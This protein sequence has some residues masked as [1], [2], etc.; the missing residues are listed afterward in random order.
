MSQKEYCIQSDGL[1][2]NRTVYTHIIFKNEDPGIHYH[3]FIEFF[4]VLEGEC[5]HLLEGKSTKITSG[6]ACLLTPNQVHS[7][8][9]TGSTFLHRDILFQ[10]D[11]FRSICDVY[12]P[13]LYERFSTGALCGQLKMTSE[14]LNQLELL[15]QPFALNPDLQDTVYPC[16][17]CTFII[18]AFLSQ[19]I[20]SQT[21]Y[22][23][24]I[25]KL[26]SLLS[27]PEN[28]AVDQ[29]VL[30]QSLPYSQEHICRTFKKLLG[31]TVTDYFNEQKMKYAYTLLQ[32][33]SYSIEEICDRINF[34]N[35]S[36]FYRMFKKSFHMTPR[37]VIDPQET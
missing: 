14:Q 34:N 23:A 8:Q 2:N 31:K 24:W 30:I 37:Q 27:A 7:F 1:L 35:V 22:P 11:Y 26:L 12:S 36:Y 32:S 9:K 10:T 5:I 13:D 33:S 28:F 20:S 21:Q 18:T 4:Y 6:D 25:T 19:Q 3:D 17:V 15:V 16:A 29:Q